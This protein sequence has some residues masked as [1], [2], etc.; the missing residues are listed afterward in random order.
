MKQPRGQ[1]VVDKILD[2]TN[3]LFYQQGYNATG[4]N[5]IIEEA[6]IAK[7]SLYQHFTTKTDLLIGYI[8][9]NHQG[10]ITRL[11]THIDGVSDPKQK[12]LAIFDYHIARQEFRQHGGCPFIKANDEAGMT[13]PRV[14]EKIQEVKTHAKNFIKEL[15]T[16]SG[17]KKTLTDEDLAQL[18][19]TLIEGGSVAASVFKNTGDLQASRQII[20]KL[21]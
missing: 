16:N 4:I 11:K 10:W 14:L 2:T 21:I 1:Q 15:V 12:L 8:D 3:K 7:G 18:I 5:Q 13:D 19:F 20:Q 6:G 17:H 9:L